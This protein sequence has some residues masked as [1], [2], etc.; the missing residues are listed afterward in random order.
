MLLG[1]HPSHLMAT[2]CP[3]AEE[4]KRQKARDA[5]APKAKPLWEE[6]GKRRGLLDKYDEEEKDMV[7]E[8]GSNGALDAERLKRQEEVR[9]KLAEGEQARGRADSVI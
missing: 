7:F 1:F 8:L 4:R 9:K 2:S 6:D 3:Q 5:A